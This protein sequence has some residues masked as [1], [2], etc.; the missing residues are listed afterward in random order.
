MPKVNPEIFRE[1]DVRGVVGRDLDA[2]T[3][4]LLGRGYGTYL[5]ERGQGEVL[6]GRDN[7]LSSAEFR[8]ALVRGLLSTGCRV[9]DLGLVV[10]PIFY[11]ARIH[12]GVDG[13]VMITGSHNPADFN[14]FK[15]AHGFGTLY[16]E[17]IQRV[18][19]IIEAGNFRQGEG[20]VRTLD[21]VPEYRA[22]LSRRI[23]LGPRR[24]RVVVDAGNGTAGLFAPGVLEGW[25]CEVLPLYC[26][27]DPHFPHHFPDPVQA[28]NLADLIQEVRRRGADLGLSFD[29]DADRIGVVDET[30]AVLWGDLLMALYW[31]EIL[32]LH[33]GTTA[34]IEVKC[35][36]ALVEEVERLGGKPLFYR[37]GH[38]LIK[39]KMRE[40]GAVF[41]G[42]MSGHMFFADEYFGY[43]DALYAAGRLLR[44]LSHTD[45]SLSQLTADIPRYPS[46]PEV[47]VPCPDAVKFRVV[48]AVRDSLRAR[49]PVID[50]DGARVLFPAGWGL[51]R[52][53]NTQPVLV[54]RAEAKDQA[55]LEAIKAE[56]ANELG[57]FPEVGKLD[58]SGNTD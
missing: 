3:V 14:G 53:S 5:Q 34:I 2:A 49:Y 47:R 33:P 32:P 51:V 30:G 48:E 7:R 20:E 40:L 19:G 38:S 23:T 56:L 28:A 42:E 1:Y 44:I 37:T 31:R 29:G 6:V 16:G 54:L 45:R 39:A 36:Q 24:L 26:E 10:T 41:T 50:I 15:L 25:G 57:V 43:D 55:S 22:E 11:F 4:E 58:W 52:A 8:D 21:P 35:S 12:Y 27:S 13:G 46:T 9:V 17:E 18:R